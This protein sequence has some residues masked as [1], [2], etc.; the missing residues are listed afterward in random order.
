MSNRGEIGS[1]KSS[2][3][4]GE[5]F[6]WKKALTDIYK[7]YVDTQDEGIA[8]VLESLKTFKQRYDDISRTFSFDD[9]RRDLLE[10]RDCDE[11]NLKGPALIV[12][13]KGKD[14]LFLISSQQLEPIRILFDVDPVVNGTS[15]YYCDASI[16][17]VK[18]P[19]AESI[20]VAVQYLPVKLRNGNN[21]MIS[22]GLADKL[23]VK[24]NDEIRIVSIF[25]RDPKDIHPSASRP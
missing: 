11:L 5:G 6:S 4:S 13:T 23:G 1:G 12:Q 22:Q 10:E 14:P 25:P 7:G 2:Q 19:D 3:P 9:L 18:S 17:N 8:S 16:E 24:N 15:G 20:T 21:L